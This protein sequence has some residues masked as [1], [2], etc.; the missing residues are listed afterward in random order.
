MKTKFLGVTHFSEDLFNIKNEFRLRHYDIFYLIEQHGQKSIIIANELYGYV[1]VTFNFLQELK[2]NL[3]NNISQL[4][5]AITKYNAKYLLSFPVDE[6]FLLNKELINADDAQEVLLTSIENQVK[7]A[8]KIM[9]HR[10]FQTCFFSFNSPQVYLTR[11]GFTME[12][13]ENMFGQTLRTVRDNL[14]KL[15]SIG[16]IDF[17]FSKNTLFQLR[18]NLD[19]F[20]I[21]KEKIPSIF[22]SAFYNESKSLEYKSINDKLKELPDELLV[23]SSKTKSKID[24]LEK[25]KSNMEIGIES[26]I[27]AFDFEIQ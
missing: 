6:D 3:S 7:R 13:I 4:D 15:K 24:Y 8:A 5:S 22:I 27:I 10:L 9:Y 18:F 14:R 16:I 12:N 20:P 23:S 26:E 25:Q 2:E 19:E 21:H 17:N 1:E 11:D